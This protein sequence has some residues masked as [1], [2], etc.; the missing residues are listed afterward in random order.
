MRTRRINGSMI[1][2]IA[3]D[4]V[5][6]VLCNSFCGTGKYLD[7]DVPGGMCDGLAGAPSHGSF[8]SENVRG[9]YR[10]ERDPVRRRFGPKAS[11]AA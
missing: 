9:H 7:R 8:F 3:Y 4:E 5:R 10:R 2:R 1:D 11:G 6:S